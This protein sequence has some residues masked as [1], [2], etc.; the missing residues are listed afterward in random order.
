MQHPLSRYGVPR[1]IKRRAAALFGALA[2]AAGIGLL[3]T[4]ALAS[5][6]PGVGTNWRVFNAEPAT[7][8]F[9]DINRPASDGAGGF[10]FPVQPFQSSSTG[11]FAVYLQNNYNVS[12]TEGS[13]ITATAKWTSGSYSTRSVAPSDA[14]ARIEFQD[15]SSGRYTS[16][17]YWWYSGSALDLNSTTSGT[18]TAALSDRGHW[19]NVCGQVAS[20]TTPH[21]GPNCVG[22]IDPAVSPYDGF[23]NAMKHVKQVSLSFGSASRYASGVAINGSDAGTF[24]LTSFHIG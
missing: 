12:L 5:A 1:P 21:P 22:G 14:Y 20:D 11:S 17:D 10:E 23:T 2:G 3:I 4:P 15:V 13:T 19:S 24:D 16:N 7:S 18:I 6:A 8:F 9:W